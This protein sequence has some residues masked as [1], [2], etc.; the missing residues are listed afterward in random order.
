MHWTTLSLAELRAA[1]KADILR[2]VAQFIAAR[3][4]KRQIIRWLVLGNMEGGGIPDRI[5]VTHDDQ[6]RVIRMVKVWRDPETGERLGGTVITWDYFATGEVRFIIISDRDG[7][8]TETRR[9]RIRHFRGGGQPV[10]EEI[11]L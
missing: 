9:R 2:D 3:F 1:T 4:T 6:G 11:V 8:N 7:N 10:M 5:I